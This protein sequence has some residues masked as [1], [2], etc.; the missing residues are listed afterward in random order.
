MK[1]VYFMRHATPV[2]STGWQG[3]DDERPLSQEG[4]EQAANLTIPKVAK[5]FVSPATRAQETAELAR[6]EGFVTF[7]PLRERM[8]DWL[9]REMEEAAQGVDG[10]VLFIGHQGSFGQVLET[11]PGEVVVVEF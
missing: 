8:D 2:S 10:D 4:R 11:E 9:L 6:I 1:T 3:D 5:V 7:S